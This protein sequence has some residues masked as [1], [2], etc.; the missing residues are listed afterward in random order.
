MTRSFKYQNKLKKNIP[1]SYYYEDNTLFMNGT[2]T[3]DLRVFQEE[4][5]QKNTTLW[6]LTEMKTRNAVNYR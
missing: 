2:V 1:T 6:Q 4:G 3:E 5:W